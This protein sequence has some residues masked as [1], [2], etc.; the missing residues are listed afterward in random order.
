MHLTAEPVAR[1]V[2]Y[3][4]PCVLTVEPAAPSVNNIVPCILSFEKAAQP[5]INIVCVFKLMITQPGLLFTLF[6]AF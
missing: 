1:P 3:I 5:V 4:V 2:V 6:R